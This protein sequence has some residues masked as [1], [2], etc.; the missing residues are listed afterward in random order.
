[1]PESSDTSSISYSGTHHMD[2]YVYIHRR[3]TDGQIFYVGKG[4]G[5]RAWA[6]KNR[7][8]YWH[9]VVA[10]HGYSIEIWQYYAEETQAFAEEKR[11]ISVL[12][13]LMPL[14]NL[15]KGGEGS[16]GY[17]HDDLSKIKISQANSQRKQSDSTKLKIREKNKGEK[18]PQFGKNHST[19]T[20]EKMRVAQCGSKNHRSVPVSIFFLEGEVL[21]FPTQ[22]AAAKFLHCSKNTL[23]DWITGKKTISAKFNIER[24]K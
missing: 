16:T 1:M 12:S 5:K 11:I 24:I 19:K 22:I 23:K 14:V 21:N 9:H 10:K 7:N 17:R 2:F 4:Q 13:G 20:R 6:T 8:P 18:H 15:T 3:K